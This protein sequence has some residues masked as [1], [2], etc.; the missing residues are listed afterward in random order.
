MRILYAY[1]YTAIR[2]A[3]ITAL[4]QCIVSSDRVRHER[5]SE[6][7]LS[8]SR[9]EADSHAQ[10]RRAVLPLS[11]GA[12]SR[13]EEGRGQFVAETVVASVGRGGQRG[14]LRR[15][16]KERQQGSYTCESR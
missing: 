11:P 5:Q 1:A 6:Q 2:Y 8:P 16:G 10:W 4:T 3:V 13:D 12:A 15:A 14:D 9:A 7:Q